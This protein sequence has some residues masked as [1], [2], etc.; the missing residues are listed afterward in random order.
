MMM[1][2]LDMTSTN[3]GKHPMGFSMRTNCA[4]VNTFEE[5]NHKQEG[6]QNTLLPLCT[7]CELRT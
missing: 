2:L 5:N 3:V 4:K 1:G 7:P 6:I